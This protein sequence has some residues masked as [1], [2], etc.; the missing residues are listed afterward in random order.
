MDYLIYYILITNEFNVYIINIIYYDLPHIIH[1]STHNMI[2]Y[3][4]EHKTT[5]E[6]RL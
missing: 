6:D 1:S 2:Y 5:G 4:Y 3:T